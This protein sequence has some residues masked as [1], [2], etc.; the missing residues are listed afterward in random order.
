M[1]VRMVNAVFED[2][3]RSNFDTEANTGQFII[4][5]PDYV[6]HEVRA[7]TFC[8]QGG[9]PG[10]KGAVN[11][12]FNPDGSLRENYLKRVLRVIDACDKH[13]V[14]VI[15]GCY[16]QRQDQ[17][18]K[19]EEAVRTGVIGVARWITE[20]GRS[21]VV[22]EIANEY[23]HCGFDPPT[24]KTPEGVKPNSSD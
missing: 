4:K 18:L 21:N 5:I 8:F 10:Y 9:M 1:N 15:L 12:A 16:Y 23:G 11:S 19:D 13:S 22:L 6:T 20:I 17:I 7:F 14:V 24:L 2:R 3:N